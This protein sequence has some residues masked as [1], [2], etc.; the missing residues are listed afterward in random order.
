MYRLIAGAAPL[1]AR[2][3]VV[4]AGVGGY[5]GINA[6]AL[7]TAIEFGIQPDALPRPPSGAPLYSP[8]RPVPDDPGDGARRT[9]PS[10]A[11]AEAILTAGVLAYLQRADM[12][13]ARAQP[14]G[15]AGEPRRPR[16][17]TRPSGTTLHARHASR[18]GSWP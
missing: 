3:R 17:G 1:T 4:A 9:S 8:Y 16:A 18:P 14:P 5:V 7:A 15:R 12:R 2:R 6:A 13:A 11:S 10:P